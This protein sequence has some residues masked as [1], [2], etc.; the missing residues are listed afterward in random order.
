MPGS[1]QSIEEQARNLSTE[2]QLELLE[3][4]IHNLKRNAMRSSGMKPVIDVDELYG[5]GK[6]LWEEDAQEYVNREREDRV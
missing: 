2:E 5:A 4:L 1:L 6:G 3:R